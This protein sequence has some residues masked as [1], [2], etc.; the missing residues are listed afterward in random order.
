MEIPWQKVMVGVSCYGMSVTQC[1]AG[2]RMDGRRRSR[3]MSSRCR[4][5]GEAKGDSTYK[6]VES[7][8]DD[9]KRISCSLG[10]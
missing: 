5:D 10:R 3:V 8:V 4:V 9:A 6:E 1:R 2:G 7:T